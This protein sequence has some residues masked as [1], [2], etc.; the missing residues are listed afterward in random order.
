MQKSSI[1]WILA[2]IITLSAA[3]YQR[4]TGPTYPLRDSSVIE[5]Q[6]IN[7]KFL[8]SYVSD[9]DQPVHLIMPDTSFKASLYYRRY[10]TDK[11]YKTIVMHRF[12]DTLRAF[13]PKQ[14]P[15]GKLEYFVELRHSEK[16]YSLPADRTV[17]TR[18]KGA[19]PGAALIPH[20][21]FMFIAMLFSNVSLFEALANGP[22]LKIYAVVT[23]VLLF[24]GGMVLGPVVQKFAF[25]EFWTGVPF[26]WDLTDNKTLLAMIGW[27]AGVIAVLSGEIKKRRWWVAVA[28][29]VLLLVY[30]IPHSTM[31]SE[32]DYNKMEVTTGNLE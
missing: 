13:L 26:G 10:K 5:N 4:M 25:G 19:V 24:L 31:G 16:K 2:V 21:I 28:A 15:A 1:R 17:V 20:V 11:E 6:K 12:A 7:Y 22:K 29:I 14:P 27:A 18:Y 23:A 9:E 3:V 8:R 30:S 32:L